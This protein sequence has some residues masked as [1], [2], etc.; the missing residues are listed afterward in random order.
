MPASLN[1]LSF[2][3]KPL[4]TTTPGNYPPEGFA[5][6]GDFKGA[7]DFEL[8]GLAVSAKNH[9]LINGALIRRVLISR[10]TFAFRL[11]VPAPFEFRNE[12]AIE[13]ELVWDEHAQSLSLEWLTDK[14]FDRQGV[15][16][17]FKGEAGKPIEQ[18]AS[19]RLPFLR[20][21]PKGAPNKNA[22]EVSPWQQDGDYAFWAPTRGVPLEQLA[23]SANA[24]HWTRRHG[25]HVLHA[26]LQS[27]DAGT[28][29]CLLPVGRTGLRIYEA[30]SGL[31]LQDLGAVPLGSTAEN[32]LIAPTMLSYRLDQHNSNVG[33]N[34]LVSWSPVHI[35][36]DAAKHVSR[37]RR[38]G[39]SQI[40]EQLWNIPV[41][42]TLTGT[43]AERAAA[44]LVA[45]PLIDF[46]GSIA[47]ELQTT[48]DQP[49]DRAC[50]PLLLLQ[51]RQ[52]TPSNQ[53][54]HAALARVLFTWDASVDQ[55]TKPN[56]GS[57]TGAPL[58]SAPRIV[59][60]FALR[61]ERTNGST[62]DAT[63]PELVFSGPLSSDPVSPQLRTVIGAAEKERENVDG[64][65][66]DLAA[67]MH[68]MLQRASVEA[69]KSSDKGVLLKLEA[70]GTL[71]SERL[72]DNT[73]IW[74]GIFFASSLVFVDPL[75][76]EC[77]GAD[78]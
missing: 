29:L 52:P 28:L 78:F 50:S 22:P 47:F 13:L 56:E 41:R 15:L 67:D 6:P 30:A 72:P 16:G 60:R 1:G 69:D 77:A 18:A 11:V 3:S 39:A 33:W 59:A 42:N 26:C 23:L 24:L 58:D 53:F 49:R 7:A 74:G 32:W 17:P 9:F 43:R 38:L 51:A 45:L 20:T 66:N 4:V 64:L 44:P 25:A 35:Q 70:S 12:K 36:A 61:A 57:S 65:V 54:P 8:A 5:A 63:L 10:R 75:F 2:L 40:L 14:W 71:C 34:A 37:D 27:G 46:E 68:A 19:K 55:L 62:V 76:G 21:E 73:L 48:S 31:G